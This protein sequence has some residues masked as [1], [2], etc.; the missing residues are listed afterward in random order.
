MKNP[1]V[2]DDGTQ[3]EPRMTREQRS[4]AWR[5]RRDGR[6]FTDQPITPKPRRE[7]KAKTKP[8]ENRKKHYE[9]LIQREVDKSAY[10]A[11]DWTRTA[12]K[13]VQTVDPVKAQKYH[14]EVVRLLARLAVKYD[15]G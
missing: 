15:R 7:H 1:F 8:W 5:N 4:K 6:P 12:M 9:E 13:S 3:P 10:H 14:D 11:W 2:S